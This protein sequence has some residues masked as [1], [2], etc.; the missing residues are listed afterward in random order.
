MPTDP[1]K[2]VISGLVFDRAACHL[3]SNLFA[4]IDTRYRKKLAELLATLQL[5]DELKTKEDK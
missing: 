1:H 4:R 2:A 3:Q 5:A